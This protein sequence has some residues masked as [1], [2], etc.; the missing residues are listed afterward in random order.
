MAEQ[1]MAGVDSE[2][3]DHLFHR[4]AP[5]TC[6]SAS[7]RTRTFPPPDELPSLMSC[8]A[9]AA[10]LHAPVDQPVQ[11]CQSRLV[12]GRRAVAVVRDAPDA[13]DQSPYPAFECRSLGVAVQIVPVGCV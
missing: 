2:V 1:D 10:P 4:R 5:E 8:D 7:L 9:Y 12:L 3:G 13:F 6:A 11:G